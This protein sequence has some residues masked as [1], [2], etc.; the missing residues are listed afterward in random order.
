MSKHKSTMLFALTSSSVLFTILFTTKMIMVIVTSSFS[1][2]TDVDC[3]R[4]EI[5]TI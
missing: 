2:D 5:Q 3:V 4:I 1:K